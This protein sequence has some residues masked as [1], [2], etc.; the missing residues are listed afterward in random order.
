MSKEKPKVIPEKEETF[1]I[2]FSLQGSFKTQAATKESAV[3]KITSI[4]NTLIRHHEMI[5]LEHGIHV[6]S[7]EDIHIA[8]AF[9][10]GMDDLN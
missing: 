9:N 8:F 2:E 10:S 6:A 5:N 4:I 7:E 3:K 1:Y